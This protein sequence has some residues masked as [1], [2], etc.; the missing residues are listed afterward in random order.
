MKHVPVSSTCPYFSAC[1]GSSRDYRSSQLNQY[2][3]VIRWMGSVIWKGNWIDIWRDV[4]SR[5][6]TRDSYLGICVW[7]KLLHTFY[8]HVLN[9]HDAI[10]MKYRVFHYKSWIVLLMHWIEAP[11]RMQTPRAPKWQMFWTYTDL[12]TRINKSFINSLLS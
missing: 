1:P 3:D 11:N 2:R 12:G 7:Y 10:K 9:S 5:Y 8:Q 4:P 6:I